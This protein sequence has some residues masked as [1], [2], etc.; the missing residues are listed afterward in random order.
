MS[1]ESPVGT[2]PSRSFAADDIHR[3][4][5]PK[6]KVATPTKPR[7]T[8]PEFAIAP[9]H[10]RSDNLQLFPLIWIALMHVGAIASLFFFSWA[11][12][13][14]CLLMH[15]VTGSIGVC[16]GYHRY[17][18]HRSFK[19][20]SPAEFCVLLCGT[21]SGQG[22][23]L[24][25]A[26]NHRLHH[27]FSDRKGDP[28]SPR[29]GKWWS[30]ILWLFVPVA[31]KL[32]REIYERYIPELLE[33]PIV[34]FVDRYQALWHLMFGCSMLAIGAVFGGWQLAVSMLL[35]G[36]CMRMVLTYHG[37]WCVNSATHLWGYRNYETRDDSRN[38]WWV[39]VMSYGEGWHNNHHA[40]PRL[41]R[42]GHRWWEVDTT[43]WMIKVMRFLRLAT[44]VED[45]LPVDSDADESRM[46]RSKTPSIDLTESATK[47]QSA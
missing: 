3:P 43:W 2:E 39:A 31:P 9:E 19:L 20:T 34:R 23:P 5:Q 35:W 28:H 44:D 38:L 22:T 30:H 40:H 17:L 4:A 47:R 33:K 32:Q 18:S 42:A 36:M 24:D 21:L 25:W 37:T 45:G 26:A 46:P 6:L 14:A 29:D 10:L 8:E 7:K 12:L 27:Q 41:A 15:W 16:L 1:T 13:A 11:G